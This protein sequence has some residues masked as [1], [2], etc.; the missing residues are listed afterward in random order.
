MNYSKFMQFQQIPVI[1]NKSVSAGSDEHIEFECA[2]DG[3]IKKLITNFAVGENGTLHITP[4]VILNNNIRVDMAAYAGGAGYISGDDQRIEIDV[5]IP[6][7]RFAKICVDVEN[8][9]SEPSHLDFLALVQYEQQ[10]SDN[11]II[12]YNGKNIK[13]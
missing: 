7:E 8:T 10:F 11:S 3:A 13:G 9:G 2:D 5:H 12:G 4:Y 1:F 6:V